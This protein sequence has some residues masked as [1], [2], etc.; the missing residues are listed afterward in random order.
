MINSQKKGSVLPRTAT[1]EKCHIGCPHASLGKIT[2][3]SRRS[4]QG[5]TNATDCYLRIRAPGTAAWPRGRNK[6]TQS[7]GPLVGP[8]GCRP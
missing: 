6:P 4:E 2:L 7:A 5:N 1:I 3:E 8:P